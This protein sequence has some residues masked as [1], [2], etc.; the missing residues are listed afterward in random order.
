MLYLFYL[1]LGILPSLIWLIFYLRKDVHPEPNSMVI[2]VFFWGVLMGPAAIIIQ[3]FINLLLQFKFNFWNFLEIN[4]TNPNAPYYLL[5]LLSL[6]KGDWRFL[7]TILIIAPLPEEYLKYLVVRSNVLKNKNFDE[8]LDA[9]LYCIIAALG[10]AAIEN[11]LTIFNAENI[12]TALGITGLRFVSATFL[13]ALASGII[14]YYLA[15]SLFESHKRKRL[16]FI[17]FLI[18]IFA[19]SLYN[20]FIW[21]MDGYKIFA[22]VTAAFLVILAV[23]VS[24]QF[25]KLKK[26]SSVCEI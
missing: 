14:G 15:R 7:L 22:W 17:G 6:P 4:F 26:I 10:F 19:H 11:F 16:L 24:W 5:H 23:T 20:Y 12:E 2:R 8:P 21:I 9:M 13:H 3:S 1:S 18:A 25:K